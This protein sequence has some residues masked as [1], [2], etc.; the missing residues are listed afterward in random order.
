LGALFRGDQ[1]SVWLLLAG[2]AVA[3]GIY[4]VNRT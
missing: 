3:A 1:I 2:I 4:L